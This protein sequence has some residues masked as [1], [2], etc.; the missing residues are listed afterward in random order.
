[1]SKKLRWGILV[2][3]AALLVLLF[4]VVLYSCVGDPGKK[5]RLVLPEEIAADSGEVRISL[6]NPLLR[7]VRFVDGFYLEYEQDGVYK[8]LTQNQ[9]AVWAYYIGHLG[10]LGRLEGVRLSLNNYSEELK[11]GHYRLIKEF[12]FDEALKEE[13]FSVT[14]EFDLVRRD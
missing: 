8:L 10:P 2:G 11:P 7:T 4:G 13:P 1:M 6:R 3:A 5:V 12:W 9:N 14:A